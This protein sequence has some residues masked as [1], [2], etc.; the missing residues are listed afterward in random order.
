MGDGR[1]EGVLEFWFGS[2]PD[3]ERGPSSS[4][5]E[6]WFKRDPAFDEQIRSRFEGLV[7]QALCGDLE[8]W[9]ETPR[10][11]LA[12]VILLDQLPRNLYRHQPKAFRGDARAIEVTRRA[13]RKGHD[14]AL[15]PIE[16]A[17][18]YMPFMH[19]EDPEVQERSVNTFGALRD[20]APPALRDL[21]ESFYRHA[22]Q[23]RDTIARF[24]RFP[25]R[26]TALDR[27]TTP[28]ELKFI[29]K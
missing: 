4:V 11:A 29:D 20:T 25:G 13:I 24:G 12:L 2:L 10:G 23:H 9:A 6:R 15:H 17:F 26:N 28:E 8:T 1:A 5:S 14:E 18:L 21:L 16:Q 27:T 7:E 3:P 22:V 19:A